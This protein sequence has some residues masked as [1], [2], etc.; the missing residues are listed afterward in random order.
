M[1]R[2]VYFWTRLSKRAR[3]R[4]RRPH[5]GRRGMVSGDGPVPVPPCRMQAAIQRAKALLCFPPLPSPSRRQSRWS[6]TAPSLFGLPGRGA[7][8]CRPLGAA[9]ATR[10]WLGSTAERRE[11]PPSI[12]AQHGHSRTGYA[13]EGSECE[14]HKGSDLP[15]ASPCKVQSACAG[16]PHPNI[17]EL[18]CAL[19][20][21]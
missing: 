7:S 14:A 13:T 8:L 6:P 18:S 1:C 21:F 20:A 16:H 10:A 15:P 5:R 3:L 9:S 2:S 19:V 12:Q 17:F 4:G 11:E